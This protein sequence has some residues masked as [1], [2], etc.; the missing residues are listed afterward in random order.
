MGGIISSKNS[1]FEI[2]DK[3]YTGLEFTITIPLF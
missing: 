2:E 1:S 3:T